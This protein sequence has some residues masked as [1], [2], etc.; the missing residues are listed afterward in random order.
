ME[1]RKDY[2]L[3]RW[4]VISQGRAKR[5]HEYVQEVKKKKGLCFFCPGNEEMTP[6]EIGRIPKGKKWMIRWF[7]NKFPA[8]AKVGLPEFVMGD[9]V[10]GA[11]YGSHEVVAETPDHNKQLWDLPLRH[12]TQLIKVWSHR[13][14]ELNKNDATRYVLVF[15]NQGELAGCSLIHSHTQIASLDLVPPVV[16]DEVHASRTPKGCAYCSII[17]R[18]RKSP[19]FIH[20]NERFISFAPYASRFNYE[21]WIFP[22]R[23][24]RSITDF[25]ER[26]YTLC[27]D[28]LL[29]ILKKL[30]KLGADYNFWLHYA[31]EGKDLHFH[32]EIAPRIAPW[33][34][35]EYSS[36]IIINSVQPEGAARYYRS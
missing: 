1:L 23:H 21:A 13:V 2:I 34:G 36:G 31:P 6:P 16:N 17:K 5:K 9:L 11:A 10:H 25:K 15:K 32:I 28:A 35:F 29:R 18:E 19:R 12:V 33:A 24:V 7:P 3:N 30:R 27:A 26:D 8:V 14:V 4:V 22:R 20:E